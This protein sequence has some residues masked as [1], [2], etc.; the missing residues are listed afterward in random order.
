MSDDELESQSRCSSPR[1]GSKPTGWS[2]FSVTFR[3]PPVR[4]AVYQG[5]TSA[6]RAALLAGILVSGLGRLGEGS[7]PSA[8]SD[9]PLI[10]VG[11]AASRAEVMRPAVA[12]SASTQLQERVHQIS[13]LK[14]QFSKGSAG[15][16]SPPSTGNSAG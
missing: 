12:A 11:V 10:T 16:A 8:G 7:A 14:A 13:E 4:A 9:P 6:E 15:T 2:C 1:G 5:V 3:H